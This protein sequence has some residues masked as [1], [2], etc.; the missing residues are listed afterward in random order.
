MRM[1]MTPTVFQ[2]VV[3]IYDR[4]SWLEQYL[5]LCFQSVLEL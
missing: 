4:A 3:L 5:A 2:E 1:R